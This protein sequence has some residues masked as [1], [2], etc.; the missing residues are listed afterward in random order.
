MSVTDQKEP[1]NCSVSDGFHDWLSQFGGSLALTTYQAGRVVLLGFDGQRVVPSFTEFPIP[2]GLAAHENLLALATEREVTLFGNA[3]ALAAQYPS[4]AAGTYDALYLPRITYFTGDL[5]VHDLGFGQDGI[6]IVNTLL[7]CLATLSARE[8]FELRWKP[9]FISALA[10]ED[11]CH[12][13]GMA[14]IDG[15]P[16]YV[17]ALGATDS[18]GGWRANKVSG[19]ILMDVQSSQVV[20]SGLSMPHSPRWFDGR[21][22]FLN[23]GAGELC[24]ADLSQGSYTPVAT[25]P[26]FLRGLCFAGNHALIGLSQIRQS[27]LFGG[28]PVRERFER[29]L[30]GV[31]VVDLRSGQPVGMFEFTSGLHELFEI[32]L[33][34]GFRR[35]MIIPAGSD[36]AQDAI[37]SRAVSYWLRRDAAQKKYV[38]RPPLSN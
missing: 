30:C 7:S 22:W 34:P 35:P 8:N 21:L 25:L 10:A 24:V 2:M 31:A 38:V 36:Q 6:W 4:A 15:A 23:S 29:L 11:R 1:V 28:L 33:L 17:T 32:Q 26:G 3:P 14:M 27:N 16:R 37:A 9:P 19:G 20:L 5:R 18:A 13:N 12:L